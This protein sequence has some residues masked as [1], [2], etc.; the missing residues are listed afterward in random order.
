M[1]LTKRE[2]A[3]AEG[4]ALFVDDAMKPLAQEIAALKARLAELEKRGIEYCGVWQRAAT[5]RRGHMVTH[6]G[7]LFACIEDSGPNECPGVS[8]K[9]QL[10]AKSGRDARAPSHRGAMA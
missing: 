9:F 8:N 6:D 5:Y 4:I 2:H 10:A 7:S 1:P 3:Q